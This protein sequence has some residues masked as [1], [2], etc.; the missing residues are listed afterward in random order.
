ML[1]EAVKQAAKKGVIEVHADT[2]YEDAAKFYRKYGFKN[3]GV[4]LELSLRSN[5]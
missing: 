4:M 5:E 3:D 1:D 2:I